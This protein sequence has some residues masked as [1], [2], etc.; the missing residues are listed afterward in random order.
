MLACPL[1]NTFFKLLFSDVVGLCGCARAFLVVVRGGLLCVECTGFSLHW[2]LFLRSTGRRC[3]GSVVVVHRLSC[4]AA[5]GIFPD[6]ESNLS[7]LHWQA[8]SYPLYHQEV[9]ILHTFCKFW[10][11]FKESSQIFSTLWGLKVFSHTEHSGSCPAW[12]LFYLDFVHHAVLLKKGDQHFGWAWRAGAGRARGPGG[13]GGTVGQQPWWPRAEKARPSREPGW[14]HQDMFLGMFLGHGV[15][16]RRDSGMDSL[17]LGLSFGLHVEMLQAD[18]L[19]MHFW[20]TQS[21]LYGTDL[22][23]GKSP[24]NSSS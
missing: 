13:G 20:E 9:L 3:T 18:V 11:L 10:C 1:I 4:S 22:E 23:G 19:W 21:I 5:C 16:W 7:P 12:F 14:A 24:F 2:L 6:Q 15:A 17:W 8:D